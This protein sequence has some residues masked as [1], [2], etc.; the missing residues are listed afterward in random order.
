MDHEGFCPVKPLF[1]L[2]YVGVV[3]NPSAVQEMPV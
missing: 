3:K 1:I 2:N